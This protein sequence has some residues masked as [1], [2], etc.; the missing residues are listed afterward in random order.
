MTIREKPL[1]FD[2]VEG[3][4]LVVDIDNDNDTI[5]L[6]STEYPAEGLSIPPT[7]SRIELD[8][9]DAKTLAHWILE[10]FPEEK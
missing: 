5:W 7:V 8:F 10:K 1:V 4:R 6:E 9:E 2:D 3:D